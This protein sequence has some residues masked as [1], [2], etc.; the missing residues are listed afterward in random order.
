MSST[1]TNTCS[2]CTSPAG[3]FAATVNGMHMMMCAAC[4][5]R[6]LAGEP[7]ADVIK[8]KANNQTKRAAA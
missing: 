3:T 6:L 5:S 2:G 7:K 1:S 8:I 4:A